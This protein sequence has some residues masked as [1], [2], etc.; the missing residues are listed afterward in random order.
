MAFDEL[1][2]PD[3]QFDEAIAATNTLYGGVT[4]D[5]TRV[6]FIHGSVDPWHPLGVLSN[7]NPEALG[8][9]V[10]GTSHCADMY[11]EKPGDPIGLNNARTMVKSQ[12][13]YWIIIVK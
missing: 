5:M 11:S 1:E 2:W 8:I 9:F 12:V 7:L 4:P 6:V 13:Q 10:M 3:E